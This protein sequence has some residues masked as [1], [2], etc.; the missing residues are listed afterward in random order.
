M[1]VGLIDMEKA[2][3]RVNKE[4]LWQVFGRVILNEFRGD[5]DY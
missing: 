3:D 4:A 2:H 5:Y 1:Y